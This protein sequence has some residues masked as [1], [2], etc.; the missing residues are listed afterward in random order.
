MITDQPIL[1][2]LSPSDQNMLHEAIFFLVILAMIFSFLTFFFSLVSCTSWIPRM[3]LRPFVIQHMLCDPYNV[4]KLDTMV[5]PDSL[6][7][8]WLWWPGDIATRYQLVL[9]EAGTESIGQ[10]VGQWSIYLCM[11]YIISAVQDVDNNSVLATTS[12][13]FC[14][15]SLKMSSVASLVS[16]THSQIKINSIAHEF[17]IGFR[18]KICYLLASIF[19]TLGSSFLLMAFTTYCFDLTILVNFKYGYLCAILILVS[20]LSCYVLISMICNLWTRRDDEELCTINGMPSGWGGHDT[21]ATYTKPVMKL[22][23]FSDNL[24]SALRLPTSSYYRNA[25]YTTNHNQVNAKLLLMTSRHYLATALYFLLTAIVCGSHISLVMFDPA[26]AFLPGLPAE[27]SQAR[28]GLMICTLSAPLLGLIALEFSWLYLS[29]CQFRANC[30]FRWLEHNYYNLGIWEDLGPA[31]F[32]L[33][34]FLGFKVP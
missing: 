10:F 20:F 5:Y 30:H 8:H 25:Q 17:S 14:L 4:D 19:N 28:V 23:D 22:L 9:A 33:P 12:M 34:H 16:L 31:E 1:A 7:H 27:E 15:S 21:S 29:G 11:N 32:T 26:F 24:F 18:Q 6:G 3:F 2:S 13:D